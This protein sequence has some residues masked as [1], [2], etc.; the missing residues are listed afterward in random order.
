MGYTWMQHS[1]IRNVFSPHSRTE[2][3]PAT[4]SF[5][6]IGAQG[7]QTHAAPAGHANPAALHPSATCSRGLRN[8]P[9]GQTMVS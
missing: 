4:T 9:G 8:I 3:T 1:Q 5:A 6:G 2:M 7:L